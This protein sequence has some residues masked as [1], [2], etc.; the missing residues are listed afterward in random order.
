MVA[1]LLREPVVEER[2]CEISKAYGWL[3]AT[4]ASVAVR[5]IEARDPAALA[6]STLSALRLLPIAS[7]YG[8]SHFEEI[9]KELP[10]LVQ[11]WPD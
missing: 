8:R 9:R 5:L 4:A 6:P 10:E 11:G 2:H 3:A 7:D 1:L